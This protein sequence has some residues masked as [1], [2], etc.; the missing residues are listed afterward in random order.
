MNL[1]KLHDICSK[2]FSLH[3]KIDRNSVGS[4]LVKYISYIFHMFKTCFF[5]KPPLV[6]FD[7]VRFD[8]RCTDCDACSDV[9][10]WEEEWWWCRLVIISFLSLFLSI[11]DLGLIFLSLSSQIR[12]SSFSLSSQIRISSLLSVLDL[13]L[14]C[15]GA[16]WFQSQIWVCGIFGVIWFH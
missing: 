16:I 9:R 10:N 4:Q 13:G 6:C 3:T 12:I 2:Y 5:V 8:G 11:L 1:L 15:F 7:L 14:W